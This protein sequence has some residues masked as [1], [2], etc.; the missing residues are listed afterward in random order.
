MSLQL[1]PR[2]LLS[3]IVSFDPIAFLHLATLME[4]KLKTGYGA[5]IACLL[6]AGFIPALMFNGTLAFLAN[7]LNFAITKHTSALTLQVKPRH[8]F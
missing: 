4:H 1:F 2:Q 7:L 6:S 3:I 8:K 5:H